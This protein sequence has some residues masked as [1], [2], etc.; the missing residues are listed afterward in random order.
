MGA[1]AALGAGPARAGIS[2]VQA[3]GQPRRSHVVTRRYLGHCPLIQR[4]T[5]ML[6]ERNM[7]SG[8]DQFPSRLLRFG[9][10]KTVAATWRKGVA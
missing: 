7:S 6:P 9:I 8:V 2:L 1:D 4:S 5:L 10:A 3:V